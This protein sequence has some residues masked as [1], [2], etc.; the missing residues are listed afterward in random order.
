M[1]G[2]VHQSRCLA[3]CGLSTQFSRPSL[4]FRRCS[5]GGVPAVPPQNLRQASHWCGWFDEGP[6]WLAIV[7]LGKHACFECQF[8][9]SWF[10]IISLTLSHIAWWLACLSCAQGFHDG[11]ATPP[12]PEW[13]EC[14]YVLPYNLALSVMSSITTSTIL[15]C[16]VE[17]HLCSWPRWTDA[18]AASLKCQIEK[19]YL[20]VCLH[21]GDWFC[22]LC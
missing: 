10:L 20:K 4:K 1:C 14:V 21:H 5:M 9:I 7:V 13:Y 2:A 18:T 3:W 19:W 11:S 22:S 17:P 6:S 16:S 12:I 8:H 15:Q